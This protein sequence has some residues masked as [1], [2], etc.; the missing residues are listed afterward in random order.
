VATL[1]VARFYG[2]MALPKTYLPVL[3]LLLHAKHSFAYTGER[4]V[5]WQTLSGTRLLQGGRLARKRK[6]HLDQSQPLASL[7]LTGLR[8]GRN[9]VRSSASPAWTSTVQD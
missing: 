2:F 6:P 1:A 5:L 8:S 7:R 4:Q 9:K 3:Y